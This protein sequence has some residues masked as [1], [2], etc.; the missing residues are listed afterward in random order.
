MVTRQYNPPHPGEIL[1]ELDMRPSGLTI[2]EVADRLGVDRKTVSR[3][4]N[5][6]TGISPEMAI[7][8]GRAF[9]TSPELWINMQRNYDLWHA[10]RR[11]KK[12]ISNI[13]PFFIENTVH[14]I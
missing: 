3:I 2:K 13:K 1:W 6:H 7:L 14:S 10:G 4:V 12:K 5:G 9:N 11:I 8:L